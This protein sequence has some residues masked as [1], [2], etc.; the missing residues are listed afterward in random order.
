MP[1]VLR[2]PPYP[3]ARVGPRRTRRASRSPNAARLIFFAPK[4]PFP[5]VSVYRA[6][7]YA[8]V[9]ETDETELGART[10]A[11][12]SRS[13]CCRASCGRGH[14]KGGGT[15]LAL[16]GETPA[17]S[18]QRASIEVW[19]WDYVTDVTEKKK[20]ASREDPLV[21]LAGDDAGDVRRVF[22]RSRRPAVRLRR[23]VQPRRRS[24][25]PR[26][27]IDALDREA[28]VFQRPR[29]RG[30]GGGRVRR[31]PKT[32]RARDARSRPRVSRRT[33]GGD[34]RW[35]AR[36]ARGRQTALNPQKTKK[37][38]RV[39]LW[40]PNRGAVAR[41][42]ILDDDDSENDSGNAAC[43]PECAF[44]LH[45]GRRRVAGGARHGTGYARARRA[46]DV[47]T[48]EPTYPYLSQKRS[49]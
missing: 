27:S 15:R 3:A 22:A 19:D 44:Q 47:S 46:R 38:K 11:S 32:K 34:G 49:P 23:R 1:A 8:G 37:H 45:G 13:G 24:R 41:F 43:A 30:A 20:R 5:C 14:E 40:E 18:F 6:V 16:L 26:F 48:T 7:S 36:R 9:D 2:R 29:P 25:R 31:R 39:S 4:G 33:F 35:R 28:G 21:C 42:S 17:G 10:R 12:L